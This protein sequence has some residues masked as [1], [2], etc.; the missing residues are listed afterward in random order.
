[1]MNEVIETNEDSD[2]LVS[3]YAACLYARIGNTARALAYMEN[4]LRNGYANYHNWMNN[5][6]GYVNVEPLRDLPE[7][8][9]LMERFESIF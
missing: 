6:T 8:K 5:T 2:G 4:S 1:W 7:F 3:Y 9:A